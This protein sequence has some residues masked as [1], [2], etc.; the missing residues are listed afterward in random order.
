[1]PAGSVIVRVDANALR[2]EPAWPAWAAV[3]GDYGFRPEPGHETAEFADGAVRQAPAGASTVL[4]R[5]VEVEVPHRRIALWRRFLAT[6]PGLA[7][8]WRDPEDGVLRRAAVE[9]VQGGI[10][11]RQV[12]E[13]PGRTAWRSELTLVGWAD[14]I[15]E[16]T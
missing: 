7:L 4:R 3:L 10:A 16:E 1:M 15:I 8:R 13:A 9:A 2:V 12:N 14:D 11:A 6:A 5:A